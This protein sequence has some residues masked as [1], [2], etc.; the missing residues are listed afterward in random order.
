MI[1]MMTLK[2]ARS[3][4][5][6][7]VL[8]TAA[9]VQAGQI[10][11]I[12]PAGSTTKD[13]SVDAEA[14]FTLSNGSLQLT[15]TNLFANPKADAQTLSAISFKVSGAT[16]SGALTTTGSGLITN[17]S[18]GGAYTA[19]VTDPLNRWDATL[20]GSTVD[21]TTLTGGKPN[22]LIIG[23]D[24]KGNFDPA[25]GG[26]YSNAN[27]SIVQ[28]T[29]MVLGSAT[30]DILIKGITEGSKISDVIFQFGTAAGSN[31]VAGE[32]VIHHAPEPSTFALLGL[33]GAGFAIRTYRRRRAAAAV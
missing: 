17:I 28:H 20:S 8:S 26:K 29:P 10:Q 3:L 18:S 1:P 32:A 14:F 25:L 21:L 5:L 13:G 15:L 33:G 2:F 6:L 7:L 19:G 24:S 4:T 16:G 9:T 12:T 11:Y 30:F 27:P 31:Q 22:R 23:A